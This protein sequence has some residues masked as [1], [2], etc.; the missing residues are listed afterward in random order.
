M[1]GEWGFSSDEAPYGD[2]VWTPA[3]HVPTYTLYVDRPQ[4]VAEVW[5][6]LDEVTAEHGIVTS[7]FVPAYRERVGEVA[8][9][10]LDLAEQTLF[11]PPKQDDAP[12][13]SPATPRCRSA[14][15]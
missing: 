12:H 15:R 10:R 8:Q 7:Q 6:I 11:P 5:P 9:G 14:D 4:K 1:L 13:D 3:S 2:K